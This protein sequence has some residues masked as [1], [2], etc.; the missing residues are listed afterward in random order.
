MNSKKIIP[1]LSSCMLLLTGAAQAQPTAKC[2]V[3]VIVKEK[4]QGTPV[5][6]A[7]IFESKKPLGKTDNSGTSF[8]AGREA[9]YAVYTVTRKGFIPRDVEVTVAPDT[10]VAP[11]V[12]MDSEK[13]LE[14]ELTKEMKKENPD[15]NKVMDLYQKLN[16]SYEING[17]KEGKKFIQKIANNIEKYQN[18]R[19][20]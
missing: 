18:R 15:L 9:G 17:N 12:L 19:P 10:T 11:T 20:A 8:I 1:L 14:G 13:T 6:D 16:E 2:T 3:K 7:S 4:R 5:A